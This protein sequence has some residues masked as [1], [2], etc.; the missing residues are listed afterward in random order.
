MPRL[1]SKPKSMRLLKGFCEDDQQQDAQKS[2]LRPG[3]SQTD[4]D[5]NQS[6]TAVL[7]KERDLDTLELVDR[8]RTSGGPGDNRTLLFH[9][10]TDPVASGHTRNDLTA[11]IP[12]NSTTLLSAAEGSEGII[13]IALGSPTV[14]SHWTGQPQVATFNTASQST[15]NMSAFSS[16]NSPAPSAARTEAPKS[17]LGR[18]RALF[19][20]AAPPVPQLEKPAFYQLTTTITATR[21]NRADSHHDTESLKPVIEL[22]IDRNVG[23]TPSPPTFKANIRASRTFPTSRSTPEPT[24]SRSRAFES[25]SLPANPRVPVMRSATAPLPSNG[26]A[27]DFPAAPKLLA[28]KSTEPVPTLPGYTSLLDVSIPDIKLDRYSVMFGNLLEPTR[29]DSSSLLV[30]RQGDSEKLNRLSKLRTKEREQES[31]IDYRLQPRATTPSGPCPSP[32]LSLF[33]STNHNRAASPRSSSGPRTRKLRRSNTAPEKSPLLQVFT[34]HNKGQNLSIQQSMASPAQ[35]L[36]ITP[37]SIRSFESDTDS[38]TLVVGRTGSLHLD[39]REPE[40]EIC[41]KPPAATRAYSNPAASVTCSDSR[42]KQPQVTNLSALCS[43]PLFALVETSPPLERIQQLQSPPQP[44]KHSTSE[45]SSSKAMIGVARSISVSR[46]NSPR[47][48]VRTA[49]E[50]RSPGDRWVDKQQALTPT[51]VEVQSRKSQRVMLV[52][53]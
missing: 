22:A 28:S 18:W 49:S 25:R 38:I 26:K 2:M 23:R 30:R 45:T 37:T 50:L 21:A 46:A 51:M 9:M 43:N 12:S 5:G 47:T 14:G 53:A 41:T 16:L 39:D 4:F 35:Q 52:D 7:L 19:R 31:P 11:S 32:R 36:S 24:K 27:N 29:N 6:A 33:P 48:P 42:S 20:K 15:E 13:G 34:R 17:K 8:P 10:K 44:A 40:W 3:T 1:L